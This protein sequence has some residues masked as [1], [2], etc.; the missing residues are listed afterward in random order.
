[1]EDMFESL[2]EVNRDRFREGCFASE[3]LV[4]LFDQLT[5][6]LPD[7]VE[8]KKP[9][10][11]WSVWFS[12]TPTE[13]ATRVEQGSEEEMRELCRN[14]SGAYAFP[15]CVGLQNPDGFWVKPGKGGA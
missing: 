5:A 11:A 13:D 2:T 9:V 10:K 14:L 15:A 3:E 8:L 1:M 6:A 12:N 7:A 4:E